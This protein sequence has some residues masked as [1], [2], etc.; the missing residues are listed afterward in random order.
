MQWQSIAYNADFSSLDTLGQGSGHDVRRRH[1][2]VGVLVVLVDDDAVPAKFV[3]A[4]NLVQVAVVLRIPFDGVIDGIGQCYPCRVVFFI[5]VG[6][7]IGPGHQVE[8]VECQFVHLYSGLC[9]RRLTV[10]S[11]RQSTTPGRGQP[12]SIANKRPS[13]LSS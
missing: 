10:A 9:N 1:G 6:R 3:G 11:P 13:R 5:E 8:V 12:Q 7:Q 2:A 4:L